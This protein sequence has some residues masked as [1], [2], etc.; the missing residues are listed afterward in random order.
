M[1]RCFEIVPPAAD[2]QPDGHIILGYEDRFLRRKSLEGVDGTGFMLDLPR[3]QELPVGHWFRLEDG[4]HLEIRAANEELA[5]VRHPQLAR[6]AWHIGNRHTPCQIETERV[7]IRRDHV[8]EEMLKHLGA[9]VTMV[10]APF[11]PEGGAYG[12][13]RTHGHHH[14]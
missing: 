4:R 14:E 7:L 10:I 5:D 8:I 1:I 11:T 3:A 9:E 12:L 2:I 6:I 13:G